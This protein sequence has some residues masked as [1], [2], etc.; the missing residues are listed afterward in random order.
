M[1]NGK[2]ELYASVIIKLLQSV[3]Y[4]DDKKYWNEVLNYE[5]SVRDYFA[6]IGIELIL[7]RQDGY[8]YL[9]QMEFAEDDKTRPIQLIRKIPLTYEMSL[10]CVLLREWLDENEVK[11]TSDKLFVT[12]KQIKE[13]IDLFFKDKTNRK[14]LLDKFDTLITQAANLGFLNVNKEDKLN[15][16]N[17]QYEVKRIIKAKISNEK[18]EELKI[19]LKKHVESV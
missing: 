3:I 15:A 9:K 5:G 2:T 19:K 17:T 7:N 11:M 6:K 1:S 18:L 12:G 8:A 13:R 10:L 14:R 16:D 4:D